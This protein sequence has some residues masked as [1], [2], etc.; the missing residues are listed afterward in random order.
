MCRKWVAVRSDILLQVELR[1]LS[2]SAGIGRLYWGEG[3]TIEATYDECATGR[4]VRG[5]PV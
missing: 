1:P 2:E 4:I 3:S 5:C